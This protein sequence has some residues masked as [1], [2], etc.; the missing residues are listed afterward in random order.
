MLRITKRSQTGATLASLLRT[1]QEL[2]FVSL[3]AVFDVSLIDEA[4]S[5]CISNSEPANLKRLRG[6]AIWA[7]G[8]IVDLAASK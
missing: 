8:A 3:F 7:N 6:G 4:M 5:I 1:F 2:V